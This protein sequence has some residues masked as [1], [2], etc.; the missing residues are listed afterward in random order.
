MANIE[1]R[2]GK[3]GAVSYRITICAGYDT[4][5]RQIRHRKTFNPGP[6]MTAKQAEKAAQKEAYRMEEELKQGYA[7]D[8][9]QKF[10]DYAQY[11]L[12]L[13]LH[14]GMKRTTYERYKTL[15]PRIDEVIGGMQLR[16]IRPLHLN[17]LYACLSN[18]STRKGPGKA[19]AIVDMNALLKER[20]LS[21]ADLCR[22]SGVGRT[23]VSDICNRR[24]VVKPTAE[25]V[26]KA[27]ECN[28]TT[29]FQT[30]GNH[31]P[32]SSKTVLEYHRLIGS[33]L[34]QAEKEMIVPYNAAKKATPPK[35]QRPEV[36]YFQPQQIVEI[37]EALKDE[38]LKWQMIANLLMIT[39]CRR[40]EIAGLKWSKFDAEQHRVMVDTTLLYSPEIGLY[41]STTKTNNRRY[42]PLPEETFDLLRRYRQEQKEQQTF[43]GDRWVETDYVFTKEDGSPIRPDTITA[44]FSAFS[45]RK[46]L[47]HINPQAFRHTAASILVAQGTDVVTVS[48][49]LGHAQVSTTADIY[50][51][52][53]PIL[54][55]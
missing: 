10:Q 20:G 46:G 53:W 39:G 6:N 32:L 52:V 14:N 23:S 42:I 33:I 31:K 19:L 15:L 25:A 2:V 5:G 43:M 47:P 48:N 44:W 24:L 45:K 12:D 26:A 29:L 38:P 40:G 13:K 36:N 18:P 51:T 50:S 28:Y 17:N 27:L 34:S 8:D 7:V 37:L 55:G 4:F 3:D 1:K 16:D 54:G 49:M 22:M 41:E 35:Y 30:T 21:Q 9:H 11:V